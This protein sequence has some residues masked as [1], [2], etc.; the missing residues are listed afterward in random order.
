MKE[1]TGKKVLEVGPDQNQERLP[2]SG[3]EITEQE[4]VNELLLNS[5]LTNLKTGGK[6][7]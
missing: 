3:S 2:G 5:D 1:V 6:R 4:I 7:F